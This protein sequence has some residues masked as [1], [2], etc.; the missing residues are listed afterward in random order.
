M[1]RIIIKTFKNLKEI[2]NRDEYFKICQMGYANTFLK[3]I[4]QNEYVVRMLPTEIINMN[5]ENR[6]TDI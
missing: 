5:L 4:N 2:K 6:F 1:E 3:V